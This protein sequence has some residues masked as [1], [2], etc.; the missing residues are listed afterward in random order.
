[1][2]NPYESFLDG[3]D[4]VEIISLTPD[5]LK[6]LSAVPSRTPEPGK[7]SVREVVCHLADSELT[8]AFRIRQSLAEDHHTIQ[9]FDQDRWAVTYASYDLPHALAT[10]D[11]VRRWNLKLVRSLPPEAFEKPVTH[12]E[13]G[14]MTFRTLIETM[15]GHDL[16]HIRQIEQLRAG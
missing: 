1:M 14:R 10:F 11:T 12:P 6:E 13:R 15:A 2:L 7:W 16:N 4:P 3:R 9:P 5:R 8:F